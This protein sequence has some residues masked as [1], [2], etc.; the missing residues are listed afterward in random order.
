[1]FMVRDILGW[2]SSAR[3]R[4]KHISQS[5]I[6]DGRTWQ[7]EEGNTHS[8]P[9]RG[10][11]INTVRT[12]IKSL[13]KYRIIKKVG[14]PTQRGQKYELCLITDAKP[15]LVSLKLRAESKSNKAKKRTQKARKVNPKNEGGI[16]PTDTPANDS[17]GISPTDTP[18]ISPTDTRGIS[19]T[20][21]NETQLK[22]HIET[23]TTSSDV[24]SE[25]QPTDTKPESMYSVIQEVFNLHGGRN[26]DMQKLLQGTATKTS[27]KPY[28]MDEPV[29]EDELR[30]WSKW[31]RQNTLNGDATLNMVTSP[32][33]VQ[34][35]IMEYRQYKL[36]KANKPKVIHPPATS[37]EERRLAQ[38]VRR[39]MGLLD[40]SA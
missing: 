24:E 35:S 6:A 9:G 22:N 11:S 36:E 20:D 5:V 12:V 2:E 33:K 32:A 14:E 29:S 18:P 28:N 40:E 27:H 31:Y 25:K 4:Q 1:M 37:E 8:K 3:T 10:L 17:E 23:H 16:S 30:S 19:P 15:D 13:I 21:D 34:S 26:G 7:D 39:S 38:I